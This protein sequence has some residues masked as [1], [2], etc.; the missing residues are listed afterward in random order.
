M[1]NVDAVDFSERRPEEVISLFWRSVY[2]DPSD[3]WAAERSDYTM[4]WGG[5]GGES[6]V[7]TQ[8]VPS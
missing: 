6:I 3:P 1:I 5:G 2:F 7:R 4:V 8:C